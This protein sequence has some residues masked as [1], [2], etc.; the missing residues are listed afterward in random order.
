MTPATIASA[1]PVSDIIP[2]EDAPIDVL[3][4]HLIACERTIYR[5]Q[6]ASGWIL[7]A[8]VTHPQTP[9]DMSSFV[10]WLAQHT[11]ML[12]SQQEVTRRLAVF[13]FYS[14]FVEK[15]PELIKLVEISGVRI[16][17]QAA[18][19]SDP[20]QPERVREMLQ[21]YIDNPGIAT[22]RR[23]RDEDEAPFPSKPIATPKRERRTV[24]ES[25][26]TLPQ[27]REML[28]EQAK[29][30]EGERLIPLVAVLKLLN[31]LEL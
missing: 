5:Y 3:L 13:R 16:A 23:P 17:Y 27:V 28:M 20:R 21:S 15:D 18:K 2:P 4:K 19:A 25:R 29:T 8:L 22:I 1:T 30:I 6:W 7:D 14:R 12:L 11:G 9:E 24:K 10:E 31:R 26:L